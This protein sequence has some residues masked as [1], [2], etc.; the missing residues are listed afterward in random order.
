MLTALKN[1]RSMTFYQIPSIFPRPK[2]SADDSILITS[3]SVSHMTHTTGMVTSGFNNQLNSYLSLIRNAQQDLSARTQ[4]YLAKVYQSNPSPSA[5]LLRDRNT[6]SE[7]KQLATREELMKL[8]IGGKANL[9]LSNQQLDELMNRISDQNLA[10]TTDKEIEDIIDSIIRPDDRQYMAALKEFK[11]S[12][13]TSHL[14]QPS[15]L[16]ALKKELETI[17]LDHITGSQYKQLKENFL[18]RPEYHHRESISSDPTKQSDA[19]NIDILNTTEHDKRH[20]HLNDNGEKSIN[21]KE[22]VKETLNNRRQELKDANSKRVFKNELHGLGIVV[23]IGVGIGFTIGFITALAQGGINPDSLKHATATGVKGGLESGALSAVGYGIGRTI[24]N[25]ASQAI[26]GVMGNIGITITDSIA[27]M[28]SMGIVGTLTITVFSAYQFINLKF[29]G[30]STREA[31]IQTGRQTLFSLSVLAVS[32]AAQGIWRG[33]A[34]IIVSISAGIVMITYS[35][36][37][38]I[39]Q[40]QFADRIRIYTINKCFP[41]FTLEAQS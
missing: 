39:H 30:V 40:R 16:V 8:Q 17:D 34:G 13:R 36:V 23:A 10:S 24:G 22:P 21:Y 4:A 2:T 9:P 3:V 28:V 29:K 27:K 15:K 12:G 6:W 11:I 25:I 7:V 18:E 20:T 19:D 37:D 33:S 14:L 38:S 32:I 35:V 5:T 1:N 41:A 31:L 26:T